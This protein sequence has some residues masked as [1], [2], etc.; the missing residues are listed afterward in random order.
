[1]KN[2]FII[3]C[4][5]FC[6]PAYSQTKQIK[7][8]IID[9]SVNKY[10]KGASVVILN[11]KD[12]IIVAD[13]RCDQYGFFKFSNI[14]D[15]RRYFLFISHPA[16]ASYS[17]NIDFND[18]SK[19]GLN[20]GNINLKSTE[21]LLKEVVVKSRLRDI[22]IRGDTIQYQ[23][24]GIQLPPNATVE[25]LLKVL[26]G[27]QVDQ[28]GRIT[29]QGKKIKK[30][31]VDGE[32]FFSDDPTFVT[33]NL[34][35]EMVS[36]VQIYDKKS[37][38]DLF[39][40]NENGEKD[41]VIN[42]QL[43]DDKNN[44]L[45]GRVDVGV[46][47]GD[48]RTQYNSQGMLN[49]FKNKRKASVYFM[50]NNTG[51]IGLASSEKSRLGVTN[52]LEKYDG[53]G[54][55]EFTSIGLHFDNKWNKDRATINGDYYF[56][57]FNISGYDSSFSQNNL[58][59]GKISRNSNNIF[60]NENLSHKTNISFKHNIDS[61][62][63]ISISTAGA[64]SNNNSYQ[65][66]DAYD[67]NSS[68][69]Y[70]NITN[71]Q[72]DH[73]NELRKYLFNILWQK[74][75]KK[76]GR[77]IS[78]ALDNLFNNTNGKQNYLSKTAFYNGKLIS[79]SSK[80]LDL[81]KNQDNKSHNLML[82][83]TLTEKLSS[84]FY[85][86]AGIKSAHDYINDSDLS[87]Q[88]LSTGSSYDTQ[89]STIR[90]DKRIS[91][92]GSINLNYAKNKTRILLGG[93][94]GVAV[95]DIYEKVKDLQLNQRFMIW[96][97]SAKIEYALKEGTNFSL[98]FKGNSINP[99][100]QQLFPYAFK[101]G[102]LV[103]FF[104]NPGLKNSFSN[105]Y[106]LAYESF[107]R[108]TRAFTA[109]VANYTTIKNP[110]ST[111]TTI[112]NSGA[113]F[114]Q[115]INMDGNVNNEVDITGFYSRPSTKLK[116]QFTVDVSLKGGNSVSLLNGV[117]NKLNYNLLSFGVLAAKNKSGKF[118]AQ[119]GATAIFNSNNLKTSSQTLRNNYFTLLLRSSA[120]IY[121]SKSMQLHSDAE[122]MQQGPNEIFPDN[123]N[124]LIWNVWI[125][126]SFLKN[127]QFAMKLVCNDLL[128]AN[129]GFTRSASSTVFLESRFATIRR[130]FILTASWNF[131]R[132]KQ[133][134]K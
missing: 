73:S 48:Q 106:S 16:Y 9:S 24:A 44:G 2:L 86:I 18:Y 100:F 109:I 123:F 11:R 29:A 37:D 36:K 34:R 71:I 66:Y 64:I 74:K 46:G 125:S 53:K 5:L 54:L 63:T 56:T 45:F 78:I 81:L 31:L 94:A 103:T 128:N 60:N 39:T 111:G 10:L 50:S 6:I 8:Y 32:E 87:S 104:D 43:K 30:V 70:L 124:R 99:D 75:F 17:F 127:N 41:K 84:S 27:L 129:A 89:F 40:G 42:L 105:T 58:S 7:G 107:K 98:N 131:T 65:N 67:L 93:L 130:Y 121:F 117:V 69:N 47:P 95:L 62:S 96:K 122:Y 132:Y 3:I 23:T 112:N 20:L 28:N 59:T 19:D 68:G 14:K 51:Q 52:D 77:T 57:I 118:D 120:D 126:R 49:A 4:F 82:G 61:S 133:I 21:I 114:I 134:K 26:P 116:T 1:M 97:P 115:H 113:Y 108:F 83:L 55:P 92:T 38:A 101:N 91:N 90:T 25:D 119:I 102:Q 110:I 15:D 85:M 33:R 22:L 79:D 12:S 80:I 76:S 72:S 35:S 13:T 88:S